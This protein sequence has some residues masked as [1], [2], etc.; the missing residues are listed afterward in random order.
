M[1]NKFTLTEIL[2]IIG[3]IILLVLSFLVPYWIAIS[4]LPDWFKFWLLK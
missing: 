1:K 4:N 3:F 2:I